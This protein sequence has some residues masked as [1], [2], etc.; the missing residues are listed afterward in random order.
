L[1]KPAT[2]SVRLNVTLNSS[3]LFFG[4]LT[5]VAVGHQLSAVSQSGATG[6]RPPSSGSPLATS[7]RLNDVFELAQTF[8][9]QK[10][11]VRNKMRRATALAEDISA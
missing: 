6:A 2:R 3:D 7:R 9:I 11:S 1:L 10:S 8:K 5:S 4:N